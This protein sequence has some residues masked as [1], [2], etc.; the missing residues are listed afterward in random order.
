MC[1]ASWNLRLLPG[2]YAIKHGDRADHFFVVFK[3]SVEC[4]EDR[5]VY[6]SGDCFGEQAMLI[7]G[8]SP[9]TMKAGSEGATLYVVDR[10]RFQE[11][12]FMV[13]QDVA[14]KYRPWLAKEPFFETLLEFEIS[15]LVKALRE[16]R[17]K[18]GD[19][20]IAQGDKDGSLYFLLEG[21]LNLRRDNAHGGFVK[22][23]ESKPPLI[24][25]QFLLSAAWV[26]DQTV[27][28]TSDTALT[29]CIDKRSFDLLLGDLP[30]LM[31]PLRKQKML[32]QFKLEREKPVNIP[33]QRT[34]REDLIELGRLGSGMLG[35][36]NIVENRTTEEVFA[37]KSL[38]KCH[39]S[40]EKT[41][42]CIH[43]RQALFMCESDFVVKLYDCYNG[44]DHVSFLLELCLGGEL[45]ELYW[46]HGLHGRLDHA[47]Y[48]VGGSTLALEHLHARGIAHRDL[49]PENI[50]LSTDGSMK[51]AD[52]GLAK[53]VY[54][55]TGTCCG[56]MEYLA[57]EVILLDGHTVAVDWWALGILLFDL[58]T[59]KTPF[60]SSD[61]LK[62]ARNILAGMGNVGM[63]EELK[64]SAGGD[65]LIKA[66]CTSQPMERLPM[67]R[68]GVDGVKRHAWFNK[69]K[70]KTLE[71]GSLEPPFK[72][73][74]KNRR[75]FSNFAESADSPASTS[76][77]D[78]TSTDNDD[79]WKKRFSTS[80]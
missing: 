71:N 64:T 70:W 47:K 12:L 66:L 19:I 37:L 50:V 44:V 65:D 22:G 10:Q 25:S 32:A 57:P 31:V 2:E 23:D 72:P 54:G 58:M 80:T 24:G 36:V 48:Y 46:H 5:V 56:T 41:R 1:N 61:P 38:K 26:S 78:A 17:F 29:L 20:I 59:G 55:K 63:P 53:V 69:F 16:A 14:K 28:V 11:A 9:F 75:D 21:Q 79:I 74:V 30:S 73:V 33:P 35:T 45:Q 49:K 62:T 68:V 34:D 77:L 39:I 7:Q 67:T 8:P 27:T 3:G 15:E 43:E 51:L 6:K 18:R 13:R 4:V 40:R 42:Y 76:V 52:L 60:E